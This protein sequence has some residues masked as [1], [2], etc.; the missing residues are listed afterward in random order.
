MVAKRIAL[1][2]VLALIGAGCHWL[3]PRPGFGPNLT[4]H[5]GPP[6]AGGARVVDVTAPDV[7][8]GT[9]AV[10]TVR[11]DG[12][13]GALIATGTTLPLHF[14]F[15]VGQAGPGI[16]V[17]F[18]RSKVGDLKRRGLG[19]VASGMRLNQLQALGSH[20]SYHE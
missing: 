19:V 12:K 15:D 3:D 13:Q 4:V 9:A 8:D 14:T 2:V 16:H 17:F 7:P 11:L 10:T 18:V 6:G 1:V 20:N 5:V